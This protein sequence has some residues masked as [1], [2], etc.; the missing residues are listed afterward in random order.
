[1]VLLLLGILRVNAV[2]DDEPQ[3]SKIIL[4]VKPSHFDV[5]ESPRHDLFEVCEV[6]LPLKDTF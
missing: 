2:V 3:V 1:M 4:D 6:P 5:L